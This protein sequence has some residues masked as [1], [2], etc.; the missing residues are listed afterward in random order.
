MKTYIWFIL[1]ITIF[2]GCEKDKEVLNDPDIEGVY[3]YYTKSMYYTYKDSLFY[4]EYNLDRSGGL[5]DVFFA[6]ERH[7]DGYRAFPVGAWAF[8]NLGSTFDKYEKVNPKHV[9]YFKI[10][11]VYPNKIFIKS[12][13]QIYNTGI[14][15]EDSLILRFTKPY[16]VLASKFKYALVGTKKD[17]FYVK[18]GTKPPG[19]PKPFIYAWVYRTHDIVCEKYSTLEEWKREKIPYKIE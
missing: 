8:I 12:L 10:G 14:V 2:G 11:E 1:V 6:I 15:S 16:P 17:S 4:N 13:T 3:S 9:S 7:E 18:V 5:G 19:I